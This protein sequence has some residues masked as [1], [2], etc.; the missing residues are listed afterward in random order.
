MAEKIVSNLSDLT[1]EVELE[2]GKNFLQCYMI[3]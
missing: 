1:L 2:D 3:K